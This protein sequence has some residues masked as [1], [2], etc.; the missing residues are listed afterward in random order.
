MRFQRTEATEITED[1]EGTDRGTRTRQRVD[2]LPSQRANA[3]DEAVDLLGRR[4]AG[5]AGAHDAVL[6]VAEALDHRG[7]VE[8]AVRD[9]DGPRAN[10]RATSSDERPF[11][12]ERD[13]R[14]ARRSGGGP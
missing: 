11:T 13:R 14:R 7:R 4:V 1:T 6:G 3:L 5:A 12:D 9:E 2:N 10:A 8:V